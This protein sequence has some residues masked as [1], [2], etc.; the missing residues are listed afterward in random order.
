MK[1]AEFLRLMA[2]LPEGEVMDFC[3]KAVEK[4]L[5]EIWRGEGSQVRV[6]GRNVISLPWVIP[7][8]IRRRKP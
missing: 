3:A 1:R 8:T 7:A 4:F 6:A 5:P 2:R